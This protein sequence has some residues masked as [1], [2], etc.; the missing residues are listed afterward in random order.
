MARHLPALYRFFANLKAVQS[1]DAFRG[2]SSLTP[3]HAHDLLD[4][5]AAAG[6]V[7]DRLALNIGFAAC[8]YLLKRTTMAKAGT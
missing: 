1:R 4:S 7:M 6:K 3:A 8:E 2:D 5:G